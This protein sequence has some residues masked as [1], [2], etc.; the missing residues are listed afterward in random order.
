MQSRTHPQ[1]S[2]PGGP[3]V[4]AGSFPPHLAP[5]T[6]SGACLACVCWPQ[7]LLGGQGG[8]QGAPV[9]KASPPC[10]RP[11]PNILASWGLSH[12]EDLSY[13]MVT[14]TKPPSYVQFSA[15][16]GSQP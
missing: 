12:R 16:L 5:S 11:P 14:A 2:P 3:A 6:E 15:P 1:L 10:L 8:L 7:H 13:M 4:L 9:C